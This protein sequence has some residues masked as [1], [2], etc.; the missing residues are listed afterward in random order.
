MQII[1][2]SYEQ[3]E[4]ELCLKSRK[5]ELVAIYGR[6]RIGK[7]FLIRNFFGFKFS[8]YASGVNN[9]SNSIQLKNFSSSLTQYGLQTPGMI[10]D[11]FDA[12]KLLKELLEKNEVYRDPVYNKR[13]IFLDEVP[14]MDTKRSDFKAA[15]DLFWNTYASAKDDIILIVC[16]SATSWIMNNMVKDQGGFYNRITH[17]IHLLPFT[18]KECLLYSRYLNLNYNE[19]QVTRCYMVFGGVPYYYDLINPELSLD[20]NID[21]LC[22]KENGQLH[23]EYFALF[24]SLFSIN[25]KH[26][27]IIEALMKK[28]SGM[29]R[30]ELASI[31]SIGDGKSL[32][33]ALE[34]LLEC[35]FIRA[36]DN[37][38]TSK[39]GKFFQLID[40]FV[41]F[42]KTFLIKAEF[43]SWLSFINTPKYYSWCGHAFE[44]VCLN[45]IDSIKKTLGIS[46]V[47]TKE[48]S[49]R[50]KEAEKGAQIDLLIH[51]KDMVIN[52]CEMKYSS[53]P[54]VIT[55]DYQD[56]L[57]N[58]LESFM[59][60]MKP[61]EQLVLTLISFNG[62]QN[63]NYSD[64]FL[65]VIEGKDLFE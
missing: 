48:Y 50:S 57:K 21:N 59:L 9:T 53:S 44:I 58:K 56:N 7:T 12:F 36:Y 60:E 30:K 8:F 63:N 55:K 45:N 11:W 49:W 61:K 14:W 65:K 22:F 32:T 37:Y 20:Q 40:P 41:L 4:L 31:K 62:L 54:Y 51:R 13:I 24:K 34:E 5:S 23:D 10:K 52:V 1:G 39:N 3:K 28:S 43:N 42:A 47:M 6:Y 19:E 15:L 17:K 26:R 27:D 2:R 29:Q 35:G 33:C 38:K 46:G 18:L 64:L 16:G 25:G